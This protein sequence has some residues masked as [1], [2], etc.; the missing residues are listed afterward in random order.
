MGNVYC[1]YFKFN[2]PVGKPVCTLRFVNLFFVNTTKHYSVW[3]ENNLFWPIQLLNPTVNKHFERLSSIR[4]TKIF[5]L[6]FIFLQ[7]ILKRSFETNPNIRRISKYIRILCLLSDAVPPRRSYTTYI[8]SLQR[9][10]TNTV[11]Q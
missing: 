4:Q 1:F 9:I 5:E 2:H 11:N 3:W 7:R 10:T 8:Y 6:L